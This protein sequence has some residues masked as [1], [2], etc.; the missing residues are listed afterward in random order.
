M[1][2]LHSST[3]NMLQCF[4]KP[5]PNQKWV[6]KRGNRSE[7]HSERNYLLQNWYFRYLSQI[8]N[9]SKIK[10]PLN[11]PGRVHCVKQVPF[12]RVHCILTDP[13]RIFTS[14]SDV[15]IAYFPY[16]SAVLYL[17]LDGSFRISYLLDVLWGQPI[18]LAQVASASE[19]LE[20]QQNDLVF[21]KII[22]SHF[23]RVSEASKID[24]FKN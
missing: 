9:P 8:E 10:P 11:V 3:K 6:N 2:F 16:S 23:C 1:S 12:G 21:F 7:F 20:N 14:T 24:C 5:K 13:G 4:V 19:V 18:K 17:N 15:S 22:P